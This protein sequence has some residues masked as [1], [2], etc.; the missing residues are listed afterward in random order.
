MANQIAARVIACIPHLLPDNSNAKFIAPR[1][2][3]MR[4]MTYET[5]QIEHSTGMLMSPDLPVLRAKVWPARLYRLRI[6]VQF[7]CV[8]SQIIDMTYVP[9]IRHNVIE[10]KEV[11]EQE[12]HSSK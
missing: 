9:K 1:A 2:P 3:I 6:A 4:F 7:I 8:D 12:Y 11:E 10:S 5:L